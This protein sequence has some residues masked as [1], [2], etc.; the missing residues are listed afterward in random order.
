[1]ANPTIL[2]VADLAKSYG[3][4]QIFSGVT[5]QVAEREHAA[6]VGVNGAGK[7][8]LMRIIA[9]VEEQQAGYV[10]LAPGARMTYLAQETRFTSDR[11]VREEARMAFADAL[12]AADRMREIEHEMA[13]ASSERLDDLLH[14]YDRL[15]L[16]FETAGGYDVEHRTDEVLMGL[17]FGLDMFDQPVNQ[18]SGGQKTRVALAKALLAS[19]DLLLLDEPTNHLDLTMVEWLEEFLRSWTGACLVISHDRYFLDRVTTRTLDMAFGR[20]EDYP[21][22]YARYLVLREER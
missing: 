21:A 14:E 10:S 17:G 6:I 11:T 19:P 22:A 13:E 9:G 2:T 3:S 20:L 12:A 16:S 18:L 4:E 8:T 5:F 7:S 1:M 15:Q